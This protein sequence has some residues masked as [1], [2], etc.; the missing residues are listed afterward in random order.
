MGV[1]DGSW[2][3]RGGWCRDGYGDGYGGWYIDGYGDGYG[4]GNRYWEGDVG[5]NG[6]AECGCGYGSGYGH[7]Y[8]D[9][10]GYG[11]GFGGWYGYGGDDGNGNGDGLISADWLVALAR[12]LPTS[13]VSDLL[14][15]GC[16]LALWRSGSQ[17]QAVNGGDSTLIRD[18]GT[19]ETSDGP[20]ELCRPGTLHGAVDCATWE[21]E[22]LWLVALY[23]PVVTDGGGKFGSLKREILCSL[24]NWYL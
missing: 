3:E 7:G 1:N 8:G 10:D 6:Y 14:S 2:D 22:K 4:Y 5:E 19:I 13:H 9:G 17:G 15:Q 16:T 18:I 11:N 24:P 21:G 12:C 20:L 23:P